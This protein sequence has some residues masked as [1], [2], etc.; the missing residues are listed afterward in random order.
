MNARILIAILSVLILLPVTGEE[1][2][3]WKTSDGRTAEGMLIS[4]GEKHV[5]LRLPNGAEAQIETATLSVD[6][7]Q[8]IKNW[9]PSEPKRPIFVPKDALYFNG[10][11]YKVYLDQTS[12]KNAKKKAEALEGHLAS[13]KNAETQE[14]VAALA[15]GLCL[16]LGA[17]D[18]EVE[19]LWKWTDGEK[20]SYSNWD[21]GEP[22]NSSRNEHHLGIWDK[23][24]WNDFTDRSS[25]PVGY[26][27]QW[28]Q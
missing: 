24:K 18:H 25:S 23:A 5:T 21:K 22:N 11:W 28:N 16:W 3:T 1:S 26:I 7:Q 27:V 8:Y 4:K 15:D 13:V 14:M 12:W 17:S 20:V 19:K 9:I 10:S 2:R 6:D